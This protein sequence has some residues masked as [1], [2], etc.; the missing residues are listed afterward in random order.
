MLGEVHKD[1]QKI[2]E[3]NADLDLEKEWFLGFGVSMPFGPSTLTYE[4]I[5]HKYGPTVIALTGSEDWRHR[6]SFNLFDKFSDITDE[7]NAQ[8]TYLTAQAELE[9]A[10]NDTIIKVKD[11]YF[12]LKKA[13]IQINSSLSKIRYE[14]KQVEV[15]RYLA[16][17]QENT[18]AQLFENMI[19]LAQSKFSFVQAVADYHVAASALGVAM[20]DPYYFETKS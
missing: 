10:K 12:N 17:F 13:L 1:T 4:P 6:L 9:K 16:G 11:E 15:T 20:G 7:K 19:E 3:D 8:V 2:Q 5:K 14:E 18:T